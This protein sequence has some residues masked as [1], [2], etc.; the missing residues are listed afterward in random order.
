MTDPA[1]PGTSLPLPVPPELLAAFG[2]PGSARY[3][4][5]YVDADLDDVIYNDGTQSGTGKTHA[6]QMYR[7]HRAVE[8][9]LR[10]FDLVSR[11]STLML[12]FDQA[13]C[14]VSVATGEQ[15]AEFL[16]QVRPPAVELTPEQAAEV[17]AAIDAAVEKGWHEVP[18]DHEAVRKAMQED[19]ARLARV[20]SWLDLA[21]T[22]DAGRGP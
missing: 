3:V 8:P 9:L 18:V 4:V 2:Y 12:V 11:E 22:P 15:A 19:R 7:R 17:Q 13:A 5:F 6:L 14:R 16:R 10:P 21:P 1:M 20:M